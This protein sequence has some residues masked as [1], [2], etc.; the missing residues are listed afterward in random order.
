MNAK[1]LV[2]GFFVALLAAALFVG[3]GAAADTIFVYENISNQDKYTGTWFLE[4][5]NSQVTFSGDYLSGDNI[6]P[7]LYKQNATEN[8][9]SVYISYPDARIEATANGA[10][11]LGGTVQDDAVVTF[12]LYGITSG[13]EKVNESSFYLSFV[14]P[15]GTR[16]SML[17]GVKGDIVDNNTITFNLTNATSAVKSGEWKVQANLKATGEVGQ[18]VN[19]TPSKYTYGA[20]VYTF[21]IVDDDYDIAISADTVVMSNDFKVTLTGTPNSYARLYSFDS[22]AS[23]IVPVSGQPGVDIGASLGV[24]TDVS[25]LKNGTWVKITDTGSKTVTLKINGDDGKYT[26]RA[27]FY[28]LNSSGFPVKLEDEEYTA[29]ITVIEGEVTAEADKDFYYLGNDVTL[30][31]TNTESD[32]I[33]FYI[34]GS[35]VDFQPLGNIKTSVKSDDSWEEEIDGSVFTNYDAGTYTIYAVSADLEA[36]QKTDSEKDVFEDLDEYLNDYSYATV[37][38][39]LKQPFLSADLSATVVAQDSDLTISG[40]AESADQLMFYV[41]GNNKFASGTITVEDDGTFEEEIDIDEDDYATG[42]YFVVIQHPMYDKVFNVGPIYV[43]EDGT[44]VSTNPDYIQV[45][46]KLNANIVENTEGS[47]EDV[48]VKTASSKILF[49]TGK[50][51]S[52]NA[53]EALCQALD[54]QN[55]D[56]IYVKASFIVATPTASMNP[57][58]DIAKGSKLIVSGTSNMAE[59]EVVTVEMLSTAFAAIPKEAVN[60]ASFMSVTTKV[61]EDGNW[62]V[63]IDTNGLNVDEYTLSATIGDIKTSAVIVKVTEGTPATPDTPANPDTPD[64]PVTPDTPDTPTEPSTP[65]FGALAALAGLGAVAVLLLRRE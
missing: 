37:S 1:K 64:T 47:Y 42:Q 50:R 7:G 49:N 24:S 3:A 63:S 27:M 34:K 10:S 31:G 45:G 44:E 62:E 21:T 41:F 19:A 65:G 54:T 60:S 39:A 33:W 30:T 9:D 22:D 46:N 38:V 43:K 26:I 51:Q 8:A 61:K 28:T 16:T 20:T 4:G 11:I 14:D 35:N 25:N 55:I 40:T 2:S 36:V 48:D 52:A 18:L 56:D 29:K 23:K 15:D 17:G 53:A 5:G 13:Y 59:G 32:N 6:K 12:N 58:S 57:V